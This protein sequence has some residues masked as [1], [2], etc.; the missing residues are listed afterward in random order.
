M[1]E[2]TPTIIN[3]IEGIFGSRIIP[4]QP[5]WS[6]KYWMEKSRGIYCISAIC[7]GTDARRRRRR[8]GQVHPDAADGADR[9]CAHGFLPA[10]VSL[11]L[12]RGAVG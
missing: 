5:L 11:G 6:C 2:K 4:S 3:I 7:I 1:Q 8:H 12:R 10:L 9:L